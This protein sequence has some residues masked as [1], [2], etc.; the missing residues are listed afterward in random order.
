MGTENSPPNT[1]SDGT[2]P[3]WDTGRSPDIIE[4]FKETDEDTASDNT[5]FYYDSDVNSTE[6]KSCSR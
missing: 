3:Y 5:K 6:D 4:D 2:I 1:D